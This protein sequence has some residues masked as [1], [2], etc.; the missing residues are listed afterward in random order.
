MTLLMR[1]VKTDGTLLDSNGGH[2]LSKELFSSIVGC[3]VSSEDAEDAREEFVEKYGGEFDDI[4][5]YTFV[6]VQ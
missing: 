2:T 6:H 5:Y 4:R 1:L 3:L